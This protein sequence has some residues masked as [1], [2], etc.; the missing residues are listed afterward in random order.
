MYLTPYINS[1]DI[2]TARK[3]SLVSGQLKGIK[4]D[5][6]PE[7]YS[8]FLTVK[9]DTNSN[10]FFWFIPATVIFF[11]SKILNRLVPIQLFVLNSIAF[12]NLFMFH[13]FTFRM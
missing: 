10:M 11:L 7:S 5:E 8:G 13:V 1:G 4:P 6:Q 12:G 9:N 3:L 2:D